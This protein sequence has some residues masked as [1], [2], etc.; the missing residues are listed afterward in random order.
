[1]KRFVL[2][3]LLALLPTVAAAQCTGVFPNNSLCG[4][5]SGA[6]KPPGIV[7]A[8]GTI[9]V[10]PASSTNNGLPLW[11][12]TTGTLLKDGNGGTVAGSYTW[13]GTNTYSAAA[14]FNS[15]SVFNG[16]ATLAAPVITGN[17]TI[18]AVV[19]TG[20]TGTGNF[21]FRTS[22][23]INT[24][25]FT[26]PALGTPA[27]GV[28]TNATGL[29][30]TT[31]VTGN[32]PVANL[33]SGTSASSSTFWR[34]D[35][36]W[37]VPT[38]PAST[39]LETLTASNSATLQTAASWSGCSTIEF[40][41]QNLI[42]ATTSVS[43]ELQVHSGGSY[44]TTSYVGTGFTTN[45]TAIITTSQTTFIGLSNTNGVANSSPGVSGFL[46]LFN[47][48]ASALHP[49]VSHTTYSSNNIWLNNGL[50][51]SAAVVDGAQFLFSS[52]NITSGIMKV[53]CI[54]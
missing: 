4:N 15:T 21:V 36:T 18:G 25:T 9:V 51:N 53:Y 5:F 42:P 3:L 41:F 50:W 1:M 20:T 32:L 34:G 24:P 46:R 30:L 13:S 40:I 45:A 52:G 22:P 8:Q 14:T 17:P 47:P 23:T 49:T 10:G 19:T 44:Q 29:P 27:S 6:P 33:N 39:L 11:A 37:A 38:V 54:L 31:G 26:A 2:A 48:S 7:N 16:V 12:N 43:A 35:A 28:L